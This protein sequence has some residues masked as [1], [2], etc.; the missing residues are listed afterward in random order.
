MEVKCIDCDNFRI[1]ILREG[2]K[3]Y[4]RKEKRKFKSRQKYN[5]ESNDVQKLVNCKEFIILKGN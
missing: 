1:Q 2:L 3:P 4:C 5:P